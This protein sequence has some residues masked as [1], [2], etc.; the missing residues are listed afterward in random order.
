MAVTSRFTVLIVMFIGFNAMPTRAQN[1]YMVLFKDKANTP[2]TKTDSLNFLSQKAIDRRIAQHIA[3]DMR[4]LPVDPAYVRA[5]SDLGVSTFYTTRWMNGVLV[6]CAAGLVATIQALPFVD[7][8]V[9]AAPGKRLNET[10][11]NRNTGRKKQTQAGET[12]AAQN[13]TIGIDYMHE[14]GYHGEG[15]TIAV[16]D[17][18]FPGVNTATPFHDLIADG[19][20]DI[21]ASYDFVFN[22]PQVFQYD[23]H[24][25][26]V[27]STMTAYVPDAFVG[28][29]YK[30]R[31]QLYVTED[32]DSEFRIEE[33]N[34]LFAA[35]HADSA[36][37]DII[38][39]SLGYYDF[40]DTS[41][42]YAQ[43]DMNGTTT[44]VTRAAQWASERGIVVV[45]AAGNEGTLP[46]KIIAAPADAPGVLAVGNV[47]SSG[48][49]ATTSSTGPT[50]DGRIK[51]DV[52]ALGQSISVIV[53]SGSVGA[54]SGTSVAAPQVAA[55]VAGVWQ[56]YPRLTALEVVALIKNTASQ[57]STPDNQI[58][59]GIPN[60][61]AIVN[62]QETVTQEQPFI[63]YPNP[64]I[65]TLHIRPNDI[66][67]IPNCQLELISALG[68]KIA[69]ADVTFD[70]L[71]R[72]YE[73]NL[74]TLSPGLYILNI[75]TPSRRFTFRVIKR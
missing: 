63:V 27:L 54:E 41:M 28:G 47:N 22:T 51:P 73:T 43:A 7:R 67:E 58:G 2:F 50:A 65:D 46:W 4:D 15:V 16:L 3:L 14:Q 44:V 5:I 10:G 39:S 61:K 6:Q 38:S 71:N 48:T 59:Y 55:L 1:R 36:G 37:V 17:G 53:E 19:R 30:A 21:D 70:I 18:G 66:S 24:G 69:T 56:H 74:A 64:F 20:I 57:A 42:N 13:R 49:R 29:A 35:E 34:W 12:T 33:Y 31:Y 26:E 60:F 23:R 75:T 32:V 45:S 72:T 8:I 68:T 11:R 62:Y 52:A 9:Y 40:D 25:T